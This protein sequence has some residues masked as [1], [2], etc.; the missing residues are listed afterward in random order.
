MEKTNRKLLIVG[1]CCLLLCV[2]GVISFNTLNFVKKDGR[3]A[4]VDLTSLQASAQTGGEGH[5]PANCLQIHER[6]NHSKLKDSGLDCMVE[7]T[8]PDMNEGDVQS[9]VPIAL[10]TYCNATSCKTSSGCYTN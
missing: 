3:L 5:A 8:G 6:V 9:C 2:L 4:S 1:K 7:V 10:D